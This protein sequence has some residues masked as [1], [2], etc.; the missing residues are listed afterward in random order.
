M[1]ILITGSTGFVGQNLIKN[2]EKFQIKTI[3][4]QQLMGISIEDLA[5]SYFIIH[6]AGK[7]HDLKKTSN[8]DEYYQVN[9]ELTKKLYDAFLKS[10]AKKFIFVS[11]VKAAADTVNDVLTE[12]SIPNPQTPYGKSK[13]MAEKYI[14]SQ[15]LPEGKSYYIL[16]PCMIHGPGNKGN[17]NLLYKFVQK[18]V[19]YPL[20]AFKN[21]RSFLSVKNL[22]F[23]IANLLEKDV[24]SG[25][26]QV[27]DDEALSTNEVVSILAESLSKKPKLWAISSVLIKGIAKLGDVFKI[28]LNTERLN[29]LTENYVVSN[30]KL[31]KALNIDLP[32]STR[33]G[34]TITA[35]SFK[36]SPD[37]HS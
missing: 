20:A 14:E 26:Y 3:N 2:L 30:Q 15:P 5:H 17:L 31:K 4:R 35:K 8:P 24:P 29:K 21:K 28:P 36:E 34:L 19:P 33:T 6:L 13:L 12:N 16:R 11:S 25:V 18:G 7:A 23:V 22:C 37:E 1:S 9:F 27:A 10:D 32:L